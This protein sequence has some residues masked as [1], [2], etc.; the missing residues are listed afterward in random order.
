MS[1]STLQSAGPIEADV[2]TVNLD[3]RDPDRRLLKILASFDDATHAEATV[4]ISSDDTDWNSG[5]P[6]VLGVC[7]G[8]NMPYQFDFGPEGFGVPGTM[9]VS[10]ASGG[11]GVNGYLT[12]QST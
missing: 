12:T 2:A 4:S 7:H 10:L 6:L 3:T 1:Y 11:A 8:G 9:T 5:D